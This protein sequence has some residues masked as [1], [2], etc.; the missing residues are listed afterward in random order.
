MRPETSIYSGGLEASCEARD[1]YVV[2]VQ[3]K[4]LSVKITTFGVAK[5]PVQPCI[6]L[7]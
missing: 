5:E 1:L 7:G 2:S 6:E 3:V 4:R